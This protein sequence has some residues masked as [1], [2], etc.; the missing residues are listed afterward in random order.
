M[1]R[2]RGIVWAAV[3]PAWVLLFPAG[4]R[5]V[6][7]AMSICAIP[8][9]CC[10]LSGVDFRPRRCSPRSSRPGRLAGRE[11]GVTAATTGTAP[12]GTTEAALP[13]RGRTGAAGAARRDPERRGL[14]GG[15]APGNAP[16]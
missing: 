2:G 4:R 3:Y 14:A 5:A 12:P 11:G 16:T 6:V 13:T 15:A 7:T 9:C 8:H 10:F 1:V